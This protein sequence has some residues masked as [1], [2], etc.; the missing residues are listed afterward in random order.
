MTPEE[1]A[2]PATPT[3]PTAPTAPAAS[4]TPTTTTSSTGTVGYRRAE[5]YDPPAPQ[6]ASDVAVTTFEHVFEVDD[7]LMERW[8]LQQEFPNWDSLRIMNSRHDHLAWMHHHFAGRVVTGSELWA[9]VE[10]ELPPGGGEPPPGGGE[11][12]P[13]GG[14]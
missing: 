6:R 9:E 7:R 13:G 12:S 3:T 10:A 14:A 4:T 8:V 5:Q 1:P 11:I 2:P